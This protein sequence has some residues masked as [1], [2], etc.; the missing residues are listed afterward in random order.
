MLH[1]QHKNGCKGHQRSNLQWH[2]IKNSMSLG[3]LFVWKVSYLH[4]KVHTKPTFWPYA[5][6]LIIM[7]LKG[8]CFISHNSIS[9][10][11][12]KHTH[13]QTCTHTDACMHI[14]AS[15]VHINLLNLHFHSQSF[16]FEADGMF[17]FSFQILSVH[18]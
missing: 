9:T 5:A 4:Q 7:S 6:L 2:Y 17:Q 12:H 13:T 16:L 15:R 1:F 14:H 18:S 3:V 8:Q 10:H 11:T